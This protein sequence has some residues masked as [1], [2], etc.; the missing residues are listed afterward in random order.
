M[1]SRNGSRY[2]SSVLLG[3]GNWI[4]LWSFVKIWWMTSFASSTCIEIEI[5]FLKMSMAGLLLLSDCSVLR[6]E[7]FSL[8]TLTVSRPR[9]RCGS[10]S[11]LLGT[12]QSLWLCSVILILWT[13][14]RKRKIEES[15]AYTGNCRK[16]SEAPPVWW[17]WPVRR[18]MTILW[19]CSVL[20]ENVSIEVSKSKPSAQCPNLWVGTPIY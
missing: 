4:L 11:P 19:Q 16:R 3:F 9:D 7:I 18:S 13:M 10:C 12:T 14:I 20:R 17:P 8:M 5:F 2:N 1:T 15:N 6:M